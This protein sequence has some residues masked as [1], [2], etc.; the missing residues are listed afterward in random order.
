MIDRYKVRTVELASAPKVD[1]AEVAKMTSPKSKKATPAPGKTASIST[2]ESSKSLTTSNQKRAPKEKSEVIQLKSDF[3]SSYATVAQTVGSVQGCLR[4]ALLPGPRPGESYS[5][6]QEEDIKLIADRIDKTVAVMAEARMFVFRAIELLVLGEHLATPKAADVDDSMDTVTTSTDESKDGELVDVLDLLLVKTAGMAI[7][8]HLFSLVLYGDLS[9][10]GPPTIHDT[11]RQVKETAKEV[12]ARLCRILPA[13]VPLNSDNITLSNLLLEAALLMI[14]VKKEDLPP[15]SQKVKSNEGTELDA[16]ADGEDGEGGRTK[17][18]KARPNPAAKSAEKI[19]TKKTAQERVKNH[20]RELIRILVY[21]DSE[22]IRKSRK[23]MQ[24]SFGKRTTTMQELASSHPDVFGAVTRKEYLDEK[25]KFLNAKDKTG[26]SCPPLPTTAFNDSPNRPP[27]FALNNMLATNEKNSMT[28]VL[29][30]IRRVEK[31]F[32]STQSVLDRFGV[33][34]LDEIDIWG[35]DPGEVN[36]A[37]FCSAAR[38]SA[39]EN[40]VV[41]RSSLYQPVLSHRRALERLKEQRIQ[42]APGQT[43]TGDCW[44]KPV[45][46]NTRLSLPSIND[47]QNILPEQQ[48]VDVEQLESSTV[49]FYQTEGLL[50]GFYGSKKVKSLNWARKQSKKAKVDMVVESIL[51]QHQGRKAMFFHGN[52]SF[53]TGLN[54]ASSHESFKTVFAQRAKAAGHGVVL[55]DE[56]LTSAMCPICTE[57]GC[58]SRLAKSTMRSC[59]NQSV[60]LGRAGANVYHAGKIGKDGEWVRKIMEDAGVDTT[61]VKVSEK[62]ATGRAIIQLSQESHDNSIV[63][64]PGTNHTVT[65]SEARLVLTHFG[66]GDWLVMQNE[67]SSGGDIMRAAKE[68]GLTICFNPSPMTA[69]LPKEY[70][71]HLVDYL[72]INEIEAQG[73]Y[74]YLKANK[75]DADSVSSSSHITASESFPV[76]EKA[77]QQVS[78]II[79]TLGGDGLVARFRIHED[80]VELKEFRMGIVKGNVVNTTG[81]GDTFTGYFIANLARNQQLGK[82]FSPDELRAALEE[83]SHAASLAVGKEGA[84]DSIPMKDTVD[85]AIRVK[86]KLE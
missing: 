48:Y 38:V 52:G 3:K 10:G 39:V 47:I 14:G 25:F 53:R 71:L 21:G 7:I 58:E 40:L 73:L 86:A 12:Y 4:R 17:F 84:M 26:L 76:L 78:G 60:A 67:I 11:S 74:S 32:P 27:R 49:K 6:L 59:A 46:A 68:K 41:K 13:L 18:D 44:A 37:S 80:D 16:D 56:Y 77:Y 83:A 81:A 51:K 62:E 15:G 66:E 23:V 50:H 35:V 1:D 85:T 28:R 61:Y 63:L 75:S 64:F 33:S 22:A 43:V 5:D 34:S 24:T 57:N 70:P 19:M 72:L 79:I 30:P 42:H 45:Q 20:H 29:N 69:E 55:V 36:T 2:T 9:D 8:K 31:Q 54:W 65:L 82:R